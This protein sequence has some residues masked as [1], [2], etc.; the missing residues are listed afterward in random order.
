MSAES[1][2]ES[3]IYIPLGKNILFKN[4]NCG[5]QQEKEDDCVS[6]SEANYCY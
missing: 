2:H 6:I 1:E 3:Q 5:E 4:A